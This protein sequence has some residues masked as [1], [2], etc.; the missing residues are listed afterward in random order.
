L[1]EQDVEG[2]E[3]VQVDVTHGVSRKGQ[4]SSLRLARFQAAPHQDGATNHISDDT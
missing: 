4:S 1:L 2:G 3:Q